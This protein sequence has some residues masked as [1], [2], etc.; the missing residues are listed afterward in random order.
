VADGKSCGLREWRPCPESDLPVSQTRQ[1]ASKRQP[2][3]RVLR[4][5]G[6]DWAKFDQLRTGLVT[7]AVAWRGGETLVPDQWGNETSTDYW[8][9]TTCESFKPA[10]RSDLQS[11]WARTICGPSGSAEAALATTWMSRH[12]DLKRQF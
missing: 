12:R 7:L 3:W 6:Y 5:S 2:V 9:Q 4:S 1:Q 11:A 8:S 10:S